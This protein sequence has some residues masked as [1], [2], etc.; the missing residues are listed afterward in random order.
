MSDNL[1]DESAWAAGVAARLRLLQ[2]SCADATSAQRR[3][4]LH[5]ALAGEIK[6]LP[7][8]RR[9]NCLTAL[10]EHF[11]TWGTAISSPV[12]PPDPTPE[13]LVNRLA[14]L[15]T[16]LT[17]EARLALGKR[18]QSAGLSPAPAPVALPGEVV[19]DLQTALGLTQF[20][21]LERIASLLKML[22]DLL[23]KLD[24]VAC[25]TLRNLPSP[26]DSR[27]PGIRTLDAEDLREGIRAYLA[28]GDEAAL[29][30][31]AQSLPKL[32]EKHCRGMVALMASPVGLA[33]V[34][35]A[36][37]EFAKWFLNLFSPQSLE[38][39]TRSEASVLFGL[40]GNLQKRCWEKY[41]QRFEDLATAQ[42]VDKQV[43]EAVAKTAEIIFQVK[44]Y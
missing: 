41:A 25:K 28:A 19:A 14:T 27:S 35:S 31:S 17:G 15:A 6:G 1:P 34:P 30:A 44:V 40:G 33:G 20:P 8:A 11:P 39:V 10:A 16:Q 29:E 3:S 2:V 4:F 26:A 38:D 9:D 43:K 42:R 37:S 7:A 21:S 36:G 32:L 12:P 5:D 23:L 18:L 22:A 13:E 24:E